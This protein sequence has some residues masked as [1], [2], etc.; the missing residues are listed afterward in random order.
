MVSMST[1]G[2]SSSKVHVILADGQLIDMEIDELTTGK[3][4]SQSY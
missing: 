1:K 4:C 2:F 3:E